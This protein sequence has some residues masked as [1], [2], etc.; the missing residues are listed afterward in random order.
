MLHAIYAVRVLFRSFFYPFRLVKKP[1]DYVLFTL[2]GE[3]PDIPDSKQGFLRRKLLGKKLSLL[4]LGEQF[5][6]VARDQR[7][8]GVVLHSASLKL[9][10]AQLQTVRGFIAKLKESGKHVVAWGSTYDMATYYV[11]TAADEVLIARGGSIGQ[12]GISRGYVFLGDALERIGLKGDFVQ[13][14]PYKTA[15]DMLTRTRMSDEAREMANWLLEDTHASIVDDIARDRETDLEKIKAIIDGA[16]YTDEVALEAKAIDGVMN[17][18]QLPAHLGT[19]KKPARVVPYVSCRKRLL[20]RLLVRPGGYIALIRVEG[21]IVDGR[22]ERP[23]VKPPFRIPLLLNPRAG[24]LTIVQQVRRVL[25]DKHAKALVLFVDSGGGSA[26]SSEAMSS[27]LRR[28]AEE[29]PVVCC[30][31]SVAASGGYYVATPARYIVAQPGTITGSIGVLSGKIINAGML[32]KLL[33]NREVLQ[34]GEN[35]TFYGSQQPFTVEEKER[36]LESIRHTYS[37]FLKRVSD[38]RGMSSEEIDSIGGGRVWTGRQALERGLVDELGGLDVALS[39]ARELAGLH[40]R[41]RME[42]IPIPKADSIAIPSAV[43]LLSYANEGVNQLRRAHT[44]CI[45][46]LVERD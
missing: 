7:V 46:P 28:L 37:L 12:L 43:A 26:A 23:P 20:P 18:E 42:E 45:C 14:S 35:A 13:I 32:E 41:T 6:H 17:Q 19:P 34:R 4:E 38:A 1:P 24:D 29:K 33:I 10:V 44:L 30:M 11:A 3:Y 9:S 8:R 21:D 31:S 16:P 22:S 27:A 36:L 2:E 40:P 25:K 15:P 39:K 5:A